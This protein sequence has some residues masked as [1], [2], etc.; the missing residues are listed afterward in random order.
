[1]IKP[2]ELDVFV[3]GKERDRGRVKKS[4]DVHVVALCFNT[5]VTKMI[6]FILFSIKH[7]YRK[8]ERDR[9]TQRRKISKF[10]HA[11]SLLVM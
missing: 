8:R 9:E 10:M 4:L 6:S 2:S 11:A 7:I 5:A 1:M 3:G